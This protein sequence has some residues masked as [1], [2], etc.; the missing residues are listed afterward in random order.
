MRD[1]YS[2]YHVHTLFCGH[3]EGHPDDYAIIAFENGFS[4]D[5]NRAGCD[6]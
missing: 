1:Y 5:C 4:G 6:G 3:G 2:N